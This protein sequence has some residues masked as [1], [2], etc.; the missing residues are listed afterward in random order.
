MSLN[1]K[2]GITLFAALVFSIANSS[3]TFAQTERF[4][5]PTTLDTGKTL[6]QQ[7]CSV[8]HGQNAEGNGKNWR[9]TDDNG[10]Y[11]PP[12][13]NGTAHAWHHSVD[14]LAHTIRNGTMAVGGTMP[15]WREVLSDD[16]IFA[17]TM[18]ITSLWPDEIYNAWKLRNPN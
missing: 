18:W 16:D 2:A 14:A 10:N 13:L 4:N 5:D 17:I 1:I 15:P 8:C 12:P 6:F 9:L 11:P 7:Y 3:V